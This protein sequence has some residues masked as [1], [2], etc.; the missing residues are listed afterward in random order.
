[1]EINHSRKI[2]AKTNPT[3]AVPNR[4]MLKRPIMITND[5]IVTTSAQLEAKPFS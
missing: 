3:L 1:M 2:G 5:M 4:C